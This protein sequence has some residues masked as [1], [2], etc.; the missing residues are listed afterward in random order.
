MSERRLLCYFAMAIN[1]QKYNPLSL[2]FFL[3][4]WENQLKSINT[5]IY[6]KKDAVLSL[7][8]FLC[9]RKTPAH[10]LC[11]SH[12]TATRTISLTEYIYLYR[13]GRWL[14]VPFSRNKWGRMMKKLVLMEETTCMCIWVCVRDNVDEDVDCDEIQNSHFPHNGEDTSPW[15]STST[16]KK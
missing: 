2:F 4:W 16:P 3:M 13:F 11:Y 1:P 8:I 9:D 6:T 15:S 14:V 5:N 10:L 12:T 7:I